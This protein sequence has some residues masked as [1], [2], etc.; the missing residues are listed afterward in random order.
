MPGYYND[1][2]P[3]ALQAREIGLAVPLIGG[4]GWESPKL[5]EIGGRALDGCMYSNHYH[6]DDPAPAVREFVTKY[7]KRFGARPDSIAALA[8]DS[9]RVLADA[10]R[11]AGPE[12]DRK[13]LR[14]AI[15]A[16]KNFPVVTGVITFDEHRNPVGKRVVIERI[17]NN[18]LTLLKTIQP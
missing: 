7:E 3:I 12:F 17:A 8:Y 13:K 18:Q 1:V 4:D 14:D 6:S 15:A 2:G 9:M 11:R 16:T 5:I 10:M